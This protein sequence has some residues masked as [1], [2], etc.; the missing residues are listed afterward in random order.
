[1]KAMQAL[2]AAELRAA[3]PSI[4]AKE[5]YKDRSD[6]YT[7]ISTAD[8]LKSL[9]DEG[10]VP[11]WAL[12]SRIRG[13]RD[14]TERGMA[15]RSNFTRHMIRLRRAQDLEPRARSLN[16]T[17]G[18]V[19]LT[20]S[21]DGTGSFRLDPG[22]LRLAC[23]NGLLVRSGQF[24]SI[25]V[26][27]QGNI[28]EMVLEGAQWVAKDLRRA[29]DVTK[30]WSSIKLTQPAQI[31]LATRSIAA[32]FGVASPL[33]PE[34]ALSAR[35]ASDEGNDLWRVFNRIQENLIMGGVHGVSSRNTGRATTTRP[36]NAV[37][38]LMRF[39]GKLWE[40]AEEFAA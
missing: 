20:N 21:H 27:H 32:R 4:F 25:R 38:N 16:D 9:K 37:G 24:E 35:R 12:Q 19:V 29:Q 17:F 23:L 3:A 13:R 36:L 8:V 40:L 26:P 2:T 30:Q 5:K 31:E 11:V 34:L 28:I 15:T 6:R 14:E 33:T 39:N 1:M 18:E 10:F 22:L 7:Y